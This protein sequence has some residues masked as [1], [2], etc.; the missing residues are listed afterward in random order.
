MLQCIHKIL[1]LMHERQ[2]A[3]VIAKAF[4]G[5]LGDLVREVADAD[6][7]F[8]AI[9]LFIPFQNMLKNLRHAYDFINDT[10]VKIPVKLTLSASPMCMP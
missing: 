2:G 7:K 3:A 8:C 4:G 1:Q 10:T 6:Y 5:S 9:H